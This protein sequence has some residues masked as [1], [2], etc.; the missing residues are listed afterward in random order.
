MLIAYIQNI[1]YIVNRDIKYIKQ[2]LKGGDFVTFHWTVLRSILDRVDWDHQSS[3]RSKY[4]MS[5]TG[6]GRE[7]KPFG[8]FPVVNIISLIVILH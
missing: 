8:N 6:I 3:S 4:F 2:L 7:Y 1:K 5:G